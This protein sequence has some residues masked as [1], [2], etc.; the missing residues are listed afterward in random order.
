MRSVAELRL[1]HDGI[2]LLVL[3]PA[4]S[5][6]VLAQRVLGIGIT[7]LN[8]KTGDHPVENRP[9]VEAGL[10]ERDKVPDVI[11]GQIRIELD[12]YVSEL[13]LDNGFR[14]M[15]R[16]KV[17]RHHVGLPSSTTDEETDPQQYP[18]KHE[19]SH[20]RNVTRHRPPRLHGLL[21]HHD[22]HLRSFSRKIAAVSR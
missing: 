3:R 4:L 22:C 16:R 10:G 7:A 1:E 17:S 11:R 15:T 8:H 12:M 9:I 19:D 2:T 18:T 13:R 6:D 21:E 5:I 14:A 20:A